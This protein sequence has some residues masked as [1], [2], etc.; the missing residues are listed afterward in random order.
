LL[1]YADLN[2][3]LGT[4]V[5]PYLGGEIVKT[6]NGKSKIEDK[7]SM[8]VN[9]KLYGDF[10]QW[11]AET[12]RFSSRNPNLQNVPAPHTEHGRAIRNLFVAPEG[13]KLVVADYSQIEPRVLASFP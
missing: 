4:Y 6:T 3:L 9:G 10:I 7:E 5:I 8:L 11:G 2:K 1:K 13:S 12:G